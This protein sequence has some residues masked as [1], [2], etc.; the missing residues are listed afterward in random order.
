MIEVKIICPRCGRLDA[1]LQPEQGDYTGITDIPQVHWVCPFCGYP[2][3]IYTNYTY[4]QDCNDNCCWGT[5]T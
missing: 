5:T 4:W 2:D 1:Y 3:V